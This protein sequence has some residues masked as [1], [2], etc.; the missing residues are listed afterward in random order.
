MAGTW[1]FVEQKDGNIRKV[2]YEM[3]SECKKG[4]DEVAAVVFGK[5]VE[6]LA[7]AGQVRSRQSLCS[8]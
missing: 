2:T 6:G 4:G 1:V 7:R 3:L 5:G 8:R